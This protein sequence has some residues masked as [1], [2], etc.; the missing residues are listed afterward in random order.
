[1]ADQT[2]PTQGVPDAEQIL[3]G[4][5]EALTIV[6]DTDDLARIDLDAVG[7]TT[8][9]LTLPVD[10][11]AL[12]ATMSQ[13]ENRFRVYISEQQAQGFGTVGDIID[14]VQERAA[15]KAARRTT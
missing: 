11:L 7:S 6:L 10:S 13:I 5:R 14:Y 4:L 2:A 12:M 1:M 9:L 3:D 8:R 15:A